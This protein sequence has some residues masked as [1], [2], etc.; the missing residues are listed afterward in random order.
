MCSA[1]GTCI[2]QELEDGHMC[3]G[4]PQTGNECSFFTCEN[5]TCVEKY[6]PSGLPCVGSHIASACSYYVCNGNGSCVH[7]VSVGLLCNQSECVRTTCAADGTCSVTEIHEGS[8]CSHAPDKCNKVYFKS[9]LVHLLCAK[10]N[11]VSITVCM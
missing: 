1:N 7:N 6:K 3:T 2:A 5:A 11:C 4:D 9:L 8:P 10:L